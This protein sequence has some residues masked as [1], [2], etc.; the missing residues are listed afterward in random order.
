VGG[1]VKYPTA[2]EYREAI[3]I[4]ITDPAERSG[5][6]PDQITRR[7]AARRLEINPDLYTKKCTAFGISH[8]DIQ[9]LRIR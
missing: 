3:R 2:V 5:W 4:R 7:F 6:L 8:E 9:N 1:V